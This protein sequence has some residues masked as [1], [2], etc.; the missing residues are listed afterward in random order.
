MIDASTHFD[1][2]FITFML[3]KLIFV[4]RRQCRMYSLIFLVHKNNKDFKN[5]QLPLLK[6]FKMVDLDILQ[7]KKGRKLH[8]LSKVLY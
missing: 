5:L 3:K 8:N 6:K 4:K 7:S 1:E 2:G